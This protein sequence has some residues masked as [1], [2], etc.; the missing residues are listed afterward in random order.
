MLLQIGSDFE[1]RT[2]LVCIFFSRS[3]LFLELADFQ[4]VDTVTE[5]FIINRFENVVCYLHAQCLLAPFKVVITGYDDE[6]HVGMA[7]S[8]LL[9]DFQAID[10][11]YVDVHDHK[12]RKKCINAVECLRAISSFTDHFAVMSLPVKKTAETFPD[13]DLIINK[14]Y[15][16]SVHK[17]SSIINNGSL[18]C[19]H[20]PP[21]LFSV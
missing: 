5:L 6:C 21:S 15:T 1:N 19:A 16:Q 13:H 4:S 14:Q 3:L 17:I 9:N 20:T 18:I 8:C 10:N 11:R 2:L 7:G 12:I